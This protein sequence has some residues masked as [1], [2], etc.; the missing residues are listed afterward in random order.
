MSEVEK[1]PRLVTG[2]Y[3]QHGS[4]WVNK[5]TL[6]SNITFV[7]FD[8]LIGASRIQQKQKRLFL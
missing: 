6:S 2:G 4:Q 5:E 8:H 1:W 3:G 7:K